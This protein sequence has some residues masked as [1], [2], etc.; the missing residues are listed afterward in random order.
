M[1]DH[2]GEIL[3]NWGKDSVARMNSAKNAYV[4]DNIINYLMQKSAEDGLV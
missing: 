4:F 1:W 3:T 2:T